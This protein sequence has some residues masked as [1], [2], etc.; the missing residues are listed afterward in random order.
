[1]TAPMPDPMPDPMSAP[2]SLSRRRLLAALPALTALPGLPVLGTLGSASLLAACGG[3]TVDATD[4]P[5][6]ARFEASTGATFVGERVR[7]FAD[8]RGGEGRI[9][10]GLGAV[11][12][13]AEVTTPPLAADTTFRLVVERAG[14]TPATRSLRVAVGYR[15]RYALAAARASM[16]QHAAAATADGAV[17]LMGG[18]RGGN[19][20]SD[21]IDRFD[22]ATGLVTRIGRLAQGRADATATRLAGGQML[23]IGGEAGF[24]ARPAELVDER[25]GAA[26]VAGTLG[27]AR[28]EHAAVRLASGAVLVLGG[29]APGEG[30]PLGFSRSAE[31]WE[32]ATQR[33]RRLAAVMSQPRAGHSA[34]L[35]P[36]GRVLVAGGYTTSAGYV[37]AEIFDPASER[38]TALPD[39]LPLRANHLALAAP[40]GGVLL[41]G[42]ET[43]QAD[44]VDPVPL[45][46]ALRFDPATG[47]FATLPALRAPR[48]LARGVML[49]G[50]H[51]LVFGGE[52]S[53][54][55]PSASAERFD[56]ATGSRTIATLDRARR[57]HSAT[58]LASGRVAVIGGE[59]SRDF[60]DTVLLY[61]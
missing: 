38:F 13:G 50:G 58:L 42:G 19:V 45:A 2:V 10:P 11:A 16:S 6:I 39:V 1:M 46:S 41:L 24:D 14:A 7:L 53:A 61:E 25:S 29:N 60:T 44:T 9:E 37:F 5:Q 49:A 12:R 15:D 20:L 36:D 57:G 56:P 22:P 55:V 54:G 32:P 21:A 18:S 35:L 40:D 8:Y 43:V 3:G 52:E 26:R 34:T 47:R 30:N 51:A 4:P 33:F 31:L 23:L 28:V 17:L 48:T 27:V 59:D